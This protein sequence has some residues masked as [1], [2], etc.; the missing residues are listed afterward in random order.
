MQNTRV[1]H[2]FLHTLIIK[3][4]L[5]LQTLVSF[6]SGLALPLSSPLRQVNIVP[7]P[8]FIRLQTGEGNG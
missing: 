6:A 1:E 2:I 8:I 5:L 7:A 4:S 3:I